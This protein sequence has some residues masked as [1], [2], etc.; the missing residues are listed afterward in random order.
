MLAHKYVFSAFLCLCLVMS[1]AVAAPTI[2]RLGAANAYS[3]TTNVVPSKATTS[4]NL[5]RASSVRSNKTIGKAATVTKNVSENKNDAVTTQRLTVG[6]YLH[7]KGVNSGVIKQTGSSPETQSD[8][9]V[10]LTDRVVQLENKIDEKQQELTAGDG[11]VIE[12]D[13]ISVDSSLTEL[14]DKLEDKVD[15]TYL[16]DYYYTKTEVDQ[17]IENQEIQSND[18]IYDAATGERTYVSVVDVFDTDILN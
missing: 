1:N 12:N 17:A 3:G 18:T 13:V 10:N 2:K 5:S 8:D 14:P 16:S 4:Q 7:N 11:I 6:K 15:A 9:L